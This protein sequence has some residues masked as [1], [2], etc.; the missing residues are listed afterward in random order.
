MVNSLPVLPELDEHVLRNILGVFS[1]A[2][3][4]RRPFADTALWLADIAFA[5]VYKDGG[6][7]EKLQPVFS[8]QFDD[9]NLKPN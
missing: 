8:P 4:V 6:S 1:S 2:Q 7:S 9:K 3:A 5:F